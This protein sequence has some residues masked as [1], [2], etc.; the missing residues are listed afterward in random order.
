MVP[1]GSA[2]LGV[3]YFC[4]E[5]DEVWEMPD[6]QAVRMATQELDRIGILD[7]AQMFNGVKCAAEGVSDVRHRLPR[8]GGRDPRLPRAL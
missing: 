8:G 5:G 2:C 6:D 7:A 4:F 3:E 1:E